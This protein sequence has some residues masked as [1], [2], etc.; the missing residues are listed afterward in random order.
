MNNIEDFVRDAVEGGWKEDVLA[1]ANCRYEVNRL[2]RQQGDTLG[3]WFYWVV[4]EGDSI[5]EKSLEILFYEIV[6][7]PLAWQAVGKVRGWSNVSG[8]CNCGHFG[9]DHAR[10][11]GSGMHR[12]DIKNC[13]HCVC[14][15][16]RDVPGTG[17]YVK[18]MYSMMNG[19]IEGKILEEAV[20][21]D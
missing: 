9:R 7:D 12:H 8:L 6:L 17:D 1:R 2:T 15:L 14:Q 13:L 3:I 21:N 4:R 20:P 18:H 16:Y 19:I 10:E 11:G 5:C